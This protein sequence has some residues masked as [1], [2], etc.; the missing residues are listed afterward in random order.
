MNAYGAAAYVRWQSSDNK[1]HCNLLA[2]KTRLAPIKTKTIPKLELSS[3]LLGCQLRSV[4]TK[5][6]RIEFTSTLHFTDSEIVYFQLA[7]DNL[8]LGTY[9]TNRVQE[10]RNLTNI[11]EW[12]WI[13]SKNNIADILTRSNEFDNEIQTMWIQGPNFLYQP[14]TEWPT[15]TLEQLRDHRDEPVEVE[16]MSMTTN[17]TMCG[18]EIINIDQ[19][20][21]YKK[22][23]HVTSIILNIL[24]RKSFKGSGS[25]SSEETQ[26]AENLWIKHVQRDIHDWKNK[27]KRLGPFLEDD[28]I[29]VG[30]PLWT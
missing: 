29:F 16:A 8:K 6:S 4:I 13:P 18:L 23:I 21:S 12:Y 20:N 28:I 14:E 19:F 17:R 22:L 2:S 1:F 7:K 26:R 3:A 15:K 25:I 27:Y 24:E 10:I 11:V 5:E 9:V 30:T